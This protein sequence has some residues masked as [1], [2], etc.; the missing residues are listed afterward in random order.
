MSDRKLQQAIRRNEKLKSKASEKCDI[1]STSQID[2]KL[3]ESA[4]KRLR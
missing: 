1:P 3:Q 4:A 2:Y